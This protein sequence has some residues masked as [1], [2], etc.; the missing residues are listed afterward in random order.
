MTTVTKNC[1]PHDISGAQKVT[2]ETIKSV[3]KKIS[4]AK[5]MVKTKANSIPGS[6]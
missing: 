6:V 2:E 1:A 4:T 5:I 3:V